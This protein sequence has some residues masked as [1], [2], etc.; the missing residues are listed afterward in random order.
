MKRMKKGMALFLVAAIGLLLMLS[1]VAA[2]DN[3]WFDQKML[4]DFDVYEAD[5]RD[6]FRS[7][8]EI[9]DINV[10]MD[11]T[12]KGNLTIKLNQ[13]LSI[14]EAIDLLS[15]TYGYSRRWLE[16]SRTVLVGNEKSFSEFDVKETKVYRLHHAESEQVVNALKVTVPVDKI[17]IDKRTNQLVINASKLEHH[18]ISE[19]I[20]RLDREMPQINIEA[21]VEELTESASENLGL[22]WSFSDT[23]INQGKGMDLQV[24]SMAKINVEESNGNA[25]L[26]ARP[27]IS[28][29]DSQEGNIFIGE[30]Y[31]IVT[32]ETTSEGMKTTIEYVE[33]GTSLKVTPRINEDGLITVF[34]NAY[35]SSAKEWVTLNDGNTIPLI[36]TRETSSVVRLAEGE[37]FA[38]SGLNMAQDSKTDA[39]VPLLY[40]IPL[41]G[42]LFGSKLDKK[43]KSK[44]SIFLTPRIVSRDNTVKTEELEI[45]QEPVA[46]VDFSDPA[47]TETLA[48]DNISSE[49]VAV[50]SEVNSTAIVVEPEVTPIAELPVVENDPV[51]IVEAPIPDPTTEVVAVEE[52]P[53]TL[54][55]PDESSTLAE[56][57]VPADLETVAVTEAATEKVP[58]V[59]LPKHRVKY[60]AKAGDTV[61]KVAEKYGIDPKFVSQANNLP[62]Q[63]NIEA[64]KEIEVAIPENQL[65]SMKPKETIWRLS[66]RY[67]TTVEKLV[68][69][70]NITNLSE[71]KVGQQIVLPVAVDQ[72]ADSKF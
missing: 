55:V 14:R 50:E 9:G 47:I 45:N 41:L 28:T 27:N 24:V 61:D 11:P 59:E 3:K 16:D 22:K 17:G 46:V 67:G 34:V 64:G 69:L 13:G 48:A 35:V 71:V 42:R 36:A 21:R 63:A 40:R 30:R 26:L 43:N 7:I 12:V 32:T 23:T 38:L 29:L 65:Y 19:I 68:E 1:V 6:V 15:Q 70:N 52:I 66:K 39:G 44:L 51:V 56:I 62:E 58:T 60:K 54:S 53:T 5:I 37:T 10:L 49:I 4:S 57:P 31:P 33:F 25:R 72:I 20:S 2:A 8:A 18:N